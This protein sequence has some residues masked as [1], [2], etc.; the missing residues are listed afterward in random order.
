MEKLLC[1]VLAIVPRNQ[2]F[3]H[4][5]DWGVHPKNV[6]NWNKS[7]GFQR[8]K[9]QSESNRIYLNMKISHIN[10][11]HAGTHIHRLCGPGTMV[12]FGFCYKRLTFP[13][14]SLECYRCLAISMLPLPNSLK[15]LQEGDTAPWD[16]FAY[17]IDATSVCKHYALCLFSF[18]WCKGFS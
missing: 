9:L 6:V 13:G 17:I 16:F 3:R 5:D 12:T 4:G 7:V 10:Q 14:A 18:F 15:Q 1:N 11:I 2:T 8:S